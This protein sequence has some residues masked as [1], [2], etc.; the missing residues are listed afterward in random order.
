MWSIVI[1]R[2]GGAR[3]EEGLENGFKPT[4][5]SSNSNC[6]PHPSLV[7]ADDDVA[8]ETMGWILCLD[9]EA[10]AINGISKCCNVRDCS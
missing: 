1:R 10:M 4:P 7:S 5:V 2:I 8:C 3:R 6:I 9:R